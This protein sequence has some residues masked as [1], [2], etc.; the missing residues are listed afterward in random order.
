[1]LQDVVLDAGS[2]EPGRHGEPPGH[3]GGLEPADLLH[4]SDVELQMRTPGGQRVQALLR[5]SDKV[6]AE[7]G[8]YVLAGGAFEPRGRQLLLAVAGR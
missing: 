7:V 1:M 8:F 4:P 5:A 6:A 3:R 2:V